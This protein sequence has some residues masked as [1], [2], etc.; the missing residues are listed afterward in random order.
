MPENGHWPASR[1]R[2]AERL[3]GG[4]GPANV[5]GGQA[6]A[7]QRRRAMGFFSAADRDDFHRQLHEVLTRQVGAAALEQV[8]LFARQFFASVGVE[9]LTERR[10]AD[11][12]GCCLS[13]WGLLERFDPQAPQ[14]VLF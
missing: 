5:R 2:W 11:L 12:A 4:V 1:R 14:V 7:S 6:S 10:L 13:A 8:T 3:A 9:E